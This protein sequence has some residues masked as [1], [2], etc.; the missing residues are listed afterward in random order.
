M[1]GVQGAAEPRAAG[2]RAGA[3]AG[4]QG[5][6]VARLEHPHQDATL[7][8]RP[9]PLAPRSADLIPASWLSKL[10]LHPFF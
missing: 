7:H 4:A 3:G 6:R 1:S 9:D 10:P 2:E 5:G 8:Q